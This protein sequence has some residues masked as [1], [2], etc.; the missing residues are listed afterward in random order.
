MIS[1]YEEITNLF[2]QIDA[3]LKKQVNVFIIG[4]AALLHYGVGK[5]YTKD[6]DVVI[7]SEEEYNALSQALKIQGFT[8]K[9]KP[10][11]HDKLEIFEMLEKGN[12]RFDLFV[13]RVVGYFCLSDPMMEKA[14]LVQKLK[15]LQVYVCSKE[16]IVVFKSISPDRPNDIEDS[17]DLMKRG[18]NWDTIYR[19]LLV[20]TEICGNEKR[21]RELIYY[22]LERIHDLELKGAKVPIK[23][24]VEK[25]FDSFQE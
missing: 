19:E 3:S 6:I 2:Q 10:L 18:V 23:G 21:A 9:R 22:F 4:G 14:E 25:L 12:F 16:D 15:K 1:K 8:T 24:R 13:K 17:I 11:S 7:N 20:Q 5:G